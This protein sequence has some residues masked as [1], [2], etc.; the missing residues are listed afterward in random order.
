MA[1]LGAEGTPTTD[2]AL[3]RTVVRDLGALHERSA[4]SLGQSSQPCGLKYLEALT[5]TAS[6][7]DISA[8]VRDVCE[9]IDPPFDQAALAYFGY[10]YTSG[11]GALKSALAGAPTT[12]RDA[13]ADCISIGGS[14]GVDGRTFDRENKKKRRRYGD[15]EFK[16]FRDLILQVTARALVRSHSN[17]RE[18]SPDDVPSIAQPVTPVDT[19]TYYHEIHPD[20]LRRGFFNRGST[21]DYISDIARLVDGGSP[22][23]IFAGAGASPGVG[24][25]MRSGFMERLLVESLSKSVNLSR[26]RISRDDLGDLIGRI[27]TASVLS[28]PSAYLGSAVRE[29]ISRTG[30]GDTTPQ[31]EAQLSSA[32]SE[33]VEAGYVPGRFLSRA[34][35][36]CAFAIRRAKVDVTVLT[37]SFDDALL[38]ASA[39]ARTPE[40]LPPGLEAYEFAIRNPDHPQSAV[41]PRQIEVTHINGSTGHPTSP[42]LIGEGEVFA[43]H[44]LDNVLTA[45]PMTWRDDLLSDRLR[46]STALFVGNTLDDPSIQAWLAKTKY[47]QRRYA[48][49]LPTPTEVASPSTHSSDDLYISNYVQQEIVT[50]RFMH[51]GVVPIIAEHPHHI[52]QFLHEV[53]LR[54]LQGDSYIGYHER[55]SLWWDYWGKDFGYQRPAG[56]PGLRSTSLQT[57]WHD[58]PL[59]K[60]MQFL[61]NTLAE[62]DE[63]D[64]GE[65]FL[66]EVWL[67]NPHARELV[68]WARSDSLWLD[69][70]TAHRTS[71]QGESRLTTQKTFETGI[72]AGAPLRLIRGQ[73]RYCWSVPLALYREP[74]YHTPVGVVNVL[75]NI[76]DHEWTSDDVVHKPTRLCGLADSGDLAH[77]EK[78]D[79]LESNLREIILRELD[80]RTST[81]ND[82][83]NWTNYWEKAVG[84]KKPIRR[85][86]RGN[87]T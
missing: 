85:R 11:D 86:R 33:V 22:I 45:Q 21:R 43:Q 76:D 40:Y 52:P 19:Y 67:R 14:T 65:R 81:W 84:K 28:Y 13:A 75:S 82:R 16:T 63:D 27:A 34:I 56:P 39:H 44:G 54:I 77:R 2:P 53:A 25:P 48:L 23:T 24:E 61:T 87:N 5:G 3:L 17:P 73:W 50:K 32:V 79:A 7:S 1:N 57:H 69:S 47:H 12:R 26:D 35:A 18:P 30:R 71:L 42:L 9:K 60:A 80:P 38:D 59:L 36:A 58:R 64:L 70:A 49:L 6:G 46:N 74:W 55:S 66:I 72:A 20:E 37:T 31:R 29:L 10:S 41:T 15:L 83:P 4:Q 8:A 62:T 51:L 68:L 78:V